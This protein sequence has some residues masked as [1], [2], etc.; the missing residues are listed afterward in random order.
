MLSICLLR[1]LCRPCYSVGMQIGTIA[2]VIFGLGTRDQTVGWLKRV[3]SLSL[4]T[5]CSPVS[6]NGQ[7]E[8]RARNILTQALTKAQNSER[9][10]G[11]WYTDTTVATQSYLSES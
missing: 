2:K 8:K 3:T 10:G 11:S 9:L 7:W 5:C 6:G 4:S 1:V